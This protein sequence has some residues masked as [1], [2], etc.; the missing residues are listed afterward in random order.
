MR[1]GG[2]VFCAT[3]IRL[4]RTKGGLSKTRRA[5]RLFHAVG[6]EANCPFLLDLLVLTITPLLVS[7]PAADPRRISCGHV[8][9][10]R[11]RWGA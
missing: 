9:P 2:L 5:D 6:G 11:R 8:S 7:S 3:S 4:A 10:A 1:I